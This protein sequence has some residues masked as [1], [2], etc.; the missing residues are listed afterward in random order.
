LTGRFNAIGCN[1]TAS[2]M[3]ATLRAVVDR[4]KKGVGGYICFT[5]VHA[6]V[7]ANKSN[8]LMSVVNN[9]FMSLPDGKPVYWVGKAQGATEL[10]QIPGPDF[11]SRLLSYPSDTPLRHYFFGG[12]PEVLSVLLDEVKRK[13][14][15][16]E[17][18]GAESPPFRV[19]TE[20]EIQ[21]SLDRIR[22][23]AP[24]FVWVGL[25]AP[26]QELWMSQHWES[27][28]PPVLLGVGAAFDFHSNMVARAPRW[29]QKIGFEWLHRLLQEP[30][31]LWKRYLY[32]NSL[33]FWYVLKQIFG[34]GKSN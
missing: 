30:G 26:K 29:V 14:P 20:S 13:Y 32:T 18:V 3:D 5:N 15:L 2:T 19:L 1:I 33:F 28:R 25:G 8:E 7:M 4:A 24:H 12:K 11:F 34:A 22:A 31:R 21:E 16:A 6:A 23:A 9:S 27:L 10:E 17:I